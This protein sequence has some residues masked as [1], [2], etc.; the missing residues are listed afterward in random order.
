MGPFTDALNPPPQSAH[1][2]LATLLNFPNPVLA[3]MA[4]HVEGIRE[5]ISD[6]INVPMT[7]KHHLA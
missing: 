4:A 7:A 2:E 5:K 3:E 6:V 1:I